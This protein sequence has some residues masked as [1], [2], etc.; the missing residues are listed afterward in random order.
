MTAK[1]YGVRSR[2]PLVHRRLARGEDAFRKP[3]LELRS[4]G[5][6]SSRWRSARS[7]GASALAE[8][9]ELLQATCRGYTNLSVLQS[10]LDPRPEHGTASLSDSHADQAT[11]NL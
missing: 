4:H 10:T 2:L 11:A 5:R 7:S 3:G 9:H 1:G 8:Q 6:A